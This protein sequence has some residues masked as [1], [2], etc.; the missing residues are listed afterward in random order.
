MDI[1]KSSII[2]RFNFNLEKMLSYTYFF[3]KILSYTLRFRTS[4]KSL[5]NRPFFE[6]KLEDLLNR[7]AL[8][9]DLSD[10]KEQL[11]DKV[12][13]VTG[14]G[15]SIGGELCRQILKMRPSKLL[16]LDHS[17]LNLYIIDC[18]LKELNTGV[19]TQVILADIKDLQT[20]KNIFR[21]F[22]PE[23]VYHAAAYKHVHLVQNNAY[24][25]IIN[26]ILGTRNIIDCSLDY[27]VNTF[28]MI[29]TDKAVNPS[30]IMGATKRVCELLVTD[31]A[32]SSGLRY[33]SVRFGNVLG[34]SGS[35]IPL[36]KKQ[37]YAGGPIT[38]THP[39]M[40]RYF[41]LIP[42]AVKLVL[43][44]GQISSPGDVNILK[45]GEPV[46]IVDIAKKVISLMGRTEDE[47]GI[48]FIG[49]R[50]GEKLFEELYLCGNEK[51]TEHQDIMV[52]PNGDSV[53]DSTLFNG[54]DLRAITAKLINYSINQDERSLDILNHL[55]FM[56]KRK[57]SDLK[58]VV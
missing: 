52:L 33:C 12:V 18:E 5:E 30:S 20:M 10:V 57:S 45:M 50:P 9:V 19:E 13:L 4:K 54:Q 15:G 51:Q 43:K 22:K 7:P 29:S 47:I 8:N 26:N 1:K 44:A 11:K 28:V 25:S 21:T 40:T 48:K 36:L 31:A 38:I 23:Y 55:A 56:H 37:V 42:E 53:Y 6:P 14:G 3:K 16:I 46:K 17:E 34:S 35:L 32:N 2:L 58:K 39:D 27:N 49:K 41:M 24:S